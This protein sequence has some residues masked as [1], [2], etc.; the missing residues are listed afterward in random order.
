MTVCI[1][2]VPKLPEAVVYNILQ[3]LPTTS[4]FTASLVCSSWRK[5]VYNSGPLSQALLK[6]HLAVLRER[7]GEENIPPRIPIHII[8]QLL[9][10]YARQDLFGAFSSTV[11][12]NVSDLCSAAVWQDSCSIPLQRRQFAVCGSLIAFALRNKRVL[13]FETNRHPIRLL[14]TIKVLTKPITLAVSEVFV[15]VL[16]EK[17]LHLY[18]LLA[19]GTPE[20]MSVNIYSFPLPNLRNPSAIALTP[21]GNEPPLVAVLGEE[22]YLI[23]PAHAVTLKRGE[24]FRDQSGKETKKRWATGRTQVRSQPWILTAPGSSIGVSFPIYFTM[25]GRQLSVS[26]CTVGLNND[27]LQHCAYLGSAW[28]NEDSSELAKRRIYGIK[29]GQDLLGKLHDADS[30]FQHYTS[31]TATNTPNPIPKWTPKSLVTRQMESEDAV[32]IWDSYYILTET[33]TGYVR[34]V[35]VA[36]FEPRFLLYRRNESFEERRRRHCGYTVFRGTKIINGRRVGGYIAFTPSEGRLNIL[37]L[38]WIS[39]SESCDD[40]DVGVGWELVRECR[41]IAIGGGE[42]LGMFAGVARVV[43]VLEN[44]IVVVRLWTE[45]VGGV[46]DEGIEWAIDKKGGV[47]QSWEGPGKLR[48]L[49]V[50]PG[51]PTM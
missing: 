30:L 22:L 32:H 40:D 20:F 24:F 35:T 21:E 1:R 44:R 17:K 49:E 45:H 11:T 34:I 51:C 36:P 10:L 4:L 31:K 43:V 5:L 27:P 46:E 50:G 13:V 41:D 15:A 33:A 14:T 25:R 47:H 48:C 29:D 16:D 39:W 9:V 12:Y 23:H 18:Q 28:G 38:E 37:P 2:Q 8:R 6:P 42:I 7:F 3:N 19:R 26:T